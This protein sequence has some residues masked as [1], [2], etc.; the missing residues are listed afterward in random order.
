MC[1]RDRTYGYPEEQKP[2]SKD[3]VV[4]GWVDFEKEA[5]EFYG[6]ISGKVIASKPVVEQNAFAGYKYHTPNHEFK[7]GEMNKNL[8][9]LFELLQEPLKQNQNG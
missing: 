4:V 8:N 2:I 3:Y 6:W 5:V 1:I 9:E 7:W